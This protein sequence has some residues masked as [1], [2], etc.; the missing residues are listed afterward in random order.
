MTRSRR[1]LLALVA[2]V[3]VAVLVAVG[4][5]LRWL[6]GGRAQRSGVAEIPGLSAPVEVRWDR[7][8]V[9]YCEAESAED[10]AAA[11]GWLHAND[12]FTQMELGR[13][14]AAGRL[15]E[16]QG[17]GRRALSVDR[18]HRTLRFAHTAER[19]WRSA[20]EET[21][22]WLQAYAGGVNAWL[23]RRGAGDLP[24]DLALL[25]GDDFRPEPWRPQDS[26]AF[27]LL[28]ANDMSFWNDRPE[29]EHFR[30]LR[31]LGVERTLDL[32]GADHPVP[33]EV[34]ALAAELEGAES[35]GERRQEERSSPGGLEPLTADPVDAPGS[36]NW[37]VGGSRSASGAPLVAN[38][39]HLGHA[40][41]GTWYQAHLRSPGYEAAGMTLPGV[42]GVVVGRGPDVAWSLT[43]AMLDDHDLFLEEVSQGPDGSPRV[44]RGDGWLLVEVVEERLEV[45]GGEGE[46][47][48]LLAT[49][50]GPLLPAD[51]VSGLPARSL[52]WTVYRTPE[53]ASADPLA[54]FLA[55]ARA[56]TVAEARQGLRG[57]VGPAM[58]LV[59]ADRQGG[60]LWTVLGRVP[61]RLRGD[62]WLPVPGWDESYGWSGLRPAEANPSEVNP[63][64]D[65]LV[66]ANHHVAP[67]NYPLPMP[68]DYDGDFRARRIR[69]LLLAGEGW[70]AADMAAVQTDAVDLYA[71]E[72]VAAA[73]A[74]RDAAADTGGESTAE[75][76][77]ADRAAALLRRWNGQM[78]LASD[79]GGEAGG[80]DGEVGA[81]A[82]FAYFERELRR[83]IFADEAH[84]HGL[85]LFDDRE[86]LLW[87]LR[88]EMSPAWFD[89][90]ST[91]EVTE[92]RS[93]LMRAALA[94]A[95]QR[96]DERWGGDPAGWDFGDLHALTLKH[97][98]SDVPVLGRV[99][100]RGPF[101]MAGSSTTVGVAG[102]RWSGDDLPVV[103]G[104][105]MRW[106][107]DLADPDATL[108]VLPAG[109]A[110]HPRDPHYDDQTTAYLAG[111]LYPFPW[112]DEAIAAAS[113]SR[114]TLRPTA[115]GP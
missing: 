110:G 91:P 49:D 67:A 95:W 51:P 36:N 74:A 53:D 21:R 26:L 104:A 112:S 99:F 73:L 47:L 81:P 41:P 42:P 90:V 89:D 63:A 52:A 86:R 84:A 97:P 93:T 56:A 5:S 109:Q 1:I 44:R 29:E 15:A 77:R 18:E 22:A 75:A 16:L 76:D 107:T 71:R 27:V 65:L 82:L 87:A 8:G 96:A 64:T 106:V 28:M 9:P 11:L 35:D 57:Y 17:V 20:G 60:L 23:D 6:G 101:P 13:R 34:V 3:V 114:L 62:G 48:E 30:W 50:L 54:A 79:D 69:E 45:A 113:V 14:L 25:G 33:P 38:D 115:P 92:D 40:L 80:S 39:P 102:G 24:P 7:R 94:T 83:G 108:A 31:E 59:M 88:G 103:H 61:V 78:G 98:L 4:L 37:A 10:L 43:N 55:L 58:N 111:E 72:V 105:S 2:L 19:L 12:R 68:A 85:E 100:D 66:T 46:V 70:R 32:A